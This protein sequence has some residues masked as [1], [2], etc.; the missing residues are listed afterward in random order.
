MSNFHDTLTQL[1][2]SYVEVMEKNKTGCP[3]CRGPIT[4]KI[5]NRIVLDLVSE[6]QFNKKRS[7]TKDKPDKFEEMIHHFRWKITYFF[8]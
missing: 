6:I 7:E 2:I 8:S 1:K 4:N 5:E 3:E